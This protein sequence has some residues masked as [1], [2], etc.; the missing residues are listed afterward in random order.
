MDDEI[1]KY[2]SDYERTNSEFKI[3]NFLVGSSGD[4]WAQYIQGLREIDGRYQELKVL[5]ESVD[6]AEL[7]YRR[8]IFYNPFSLYSRAKAKYRKKMKKNTLE[9]ISNKIKSTEKELAILLNVVKIIKKEHIGEL[10]EKRRDELEY[11]SWAYKAVKLS[12]IDILTTG[13]MGAKT[14]EFIVS[15]PQEIQSSILSKI[16]PDD[17]KGN[18]VKKEIMDLGFRDY[19]N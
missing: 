4:A 13:R 9:K 7:D 10:D 16:L 19:R 5:R 11:K 14:L 12:T 18:N 3:R 6:M 17:K 2:L 15:L 1:K 8:K